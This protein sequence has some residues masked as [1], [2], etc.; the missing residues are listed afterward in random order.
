MRLIKKGFIE[1]MINFPTRMLVYLVR[2]YK[3]KSQSITGRMMKPTLNFGIKVTLWKLTRLGN[4][5]QPREEGNK[6]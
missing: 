5:L 4:Q 6:R 3:N 1:K 2:S